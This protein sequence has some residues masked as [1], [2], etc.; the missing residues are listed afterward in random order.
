MNKNKNIKM[1]KIKDFINN[2][3][4]NKIVTAANSVQGIDWIKKKE[5]D[6]QTDKIDMN[7]IIIN[8]QLK[9]IKKLEKFKVNKY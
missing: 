7:K 8:K 5:Y 6:Y 4:Y 3:V 2:K 9:T 1:Q